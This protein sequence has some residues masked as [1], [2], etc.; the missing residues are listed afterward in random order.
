M[1]MLNIAFAPTRPPVD[2]IGM[3]GT[4]IGNQSLEG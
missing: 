1:V 2:Y 4:G 3:I